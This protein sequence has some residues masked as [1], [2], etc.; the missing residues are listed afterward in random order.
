MGLIFYGDGRQLESEGSCS[1]RG[2]PPDWRTG[3][4]GSVLFLLFIYIVGHLL[5]FR[6]F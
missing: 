5:V 6:L 1:C 2:P 4:Y 3:F